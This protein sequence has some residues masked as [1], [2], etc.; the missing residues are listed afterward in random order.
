MLSSCYWKSIRCLF[1]FSFVSLS[2]ESSVDNDGRLEGFCLFVFVEGVGGGFVSLFSCLFFFCLFFSFAKPSARAKSIKGGTI[3]VCVRFRSTLALSHFVCSCLSFACSLNVVIGMVGVGFESFGFFLH[4]FLD[5]QNGGRLRLI[6]STNKTDRTRAALRNA[7]VF[8]WE[9]E[10]ERENVTKKEKRQWTFWW[11]PT[12]CVFLFTPWPQMMFFS[13]NYCV[14]WSTQPNATVASF[15]M[16]KFKWNQTTESG[17][18][19]NSTQSEVKKYKQTKQMIRSHSKMKK[20]HNKKVFTFVLDRSDWKVSLLVWRLRLPTLH[21]HRFVSRSWFLFF[22]GGST[23]V[24]SIFWRPLGFCVLYSATTAFGKSLAKKKINNKE[25]KW[26]RRWCGS[27]RAVLVGRAR[28]PC[29]CHGRRRRRRN[30]YFI[31]R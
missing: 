13:S 16:R 11:P 3:G 8:V 22:T 10:R 1:F 5:F 18:Q 7:S 29:R 27:I 17:Q 25:I 31:T 4:A 26:S 23:L 12:R 28:C 14:F 30:R 6:L 15:P 20:N 21:S 2:A 19:E 24:C 9:R